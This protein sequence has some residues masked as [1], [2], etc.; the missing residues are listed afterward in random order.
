MASTDRHDRLSRKL[1]W[2]LRHGAPEAGVAQ[3]A[4]GFVAID[5]ALRVAGCD[6]DTLDELVRDNAKKRFE[7]DGDRIRAVQGHSSNAVTLE[8][9]EATYTRYDGPDVI[10]HGT[11]F[12]SVSGIAERGIVAMARTH[13]HLA[14][15]ATSI[16]GKRASVD[17]FVEVSSRALAA[18]GIPVFVAPNGVLLAR[19][20]PT[21]CIVG[22][23]AARDG[24]EDRVATLAP[25][26]AFAR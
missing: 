16:V 21:E 7:I 13:V 5:D 17:V 3:S 14:P 19:R 22:L 4:D 15:H 6:R 12:A 2:L 26:F 10:L 25:L 20:V 23:R 24:V 11:S 18:H 8:A 9:L 1:S